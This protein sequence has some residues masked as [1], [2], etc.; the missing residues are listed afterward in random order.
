M[1]K[2]S[3]VLLFLII[4]FITH[5]QKKYTVD[6]IPD[7]KR[8]GQEYFVSDPDGVLSDV[9]SLNKLIIKLEKETKIEVAVV[10]VKD[11]EENLDEFEFGINLFRK[12]SIG[13]KGADNGLL[14]FASIDR[15]KYRFVTGYGLE[16]LLPDVK[17]KHIAEQNLVPAFKEQ[18]Y[19]DGIAS[20]LT[21][22]A[23][24][25]TNLNNKAEVQSLIAETNRKSNEWKD[26]TIYSVLVALFFAFAFIYIRKKAPKYEFKKNDKSTNSYD[27]KI[28]FGC[29]GIFLIVFS[30]F[31]IWAFLFDFKNP[32]LK[33]TS[34][35]II[36][37]II[38]SL[39]L[40]FRYLGMMS[41][42]R[43]AHNDDQNFFE[44]AKD[45]NKKIWPLFIFSPFILLGIWRN[46]TT[47]NKL[48]SR[49]SPLLDR[50]GK[51]M[52]RLDRDKN[53]EGKPFLSKGQRKEEV[54]LV[55]DYDIW[56]SED[57]KENEVKAWP[58]E[59]FDD[60]SE[61]P[62]CKFKTLGK[63]KVITIRR[64][65]YSTNGEGKEIQKCENCNNEVLIG[66][67][68]LAMLVES[69]SSSSGSSGSSSSSSSSS[70]SGSWGGGS[71]GGGGSGGSW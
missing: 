65:T 1:K 43:K 19:D 67:V 21:A 64:S 50:K 10:I 34:L 61:C 60:F 69:S 37:Y 8:Q 71:S 28:A 49:F 26:P 27:K 58:A 47:R 6:E 13:K 63:P 59:K 23:K 30:S 18:R 54:L 29:T 15:R 25:L 42:L 24:F 11:F 22:I 51:N 41:A 68:V 39:F 40:F 57:H 17:L 56:E 16:G 7:P 2:L 5:A 46:S 48:G 35:P 52:I 44:S 70:S 3:L 32:N 38:L 31:F 33:L 45:L 20:S 62:K 9:D 66:M 55:Y 36:L 12:W 4:G 14:L 53:I